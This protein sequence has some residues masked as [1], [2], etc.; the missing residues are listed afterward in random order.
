MPLNVIWIGIVPYWSILFI[1]FPR[2]KLIFILRAVCRN[3]PNDNNFYQWSFNKMAII[4]HQNSEIFGVRFDNTIDRKIID[5]VLLCP[6][7]NAWLQYLLLLKWILSWPEQTVSSFFES[8]YYV[9][10]ERSIH[11]NFLYF[12]NGDENIV[13]RIYTVLSFI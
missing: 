7:F 2:R 5:F 8:A 13:I 10:L 1:I 4:S 6:K 3:K 12:W 9:N 11:S